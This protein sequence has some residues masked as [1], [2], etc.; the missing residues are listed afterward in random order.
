M[1]FGVLVAPISRLNIGVHPRTQSGKG[2]SEN[3]NKWYSGAAPS[4]LR[5]DIVVA[6]RFLTR[7]PIGRSGET[8]TN[9]ASAARAFSLVGAAVGL[10]GSVAFGLAILVGLPPFLAALIA[11]GALILVTGALHEDGLADAADGMGGSTPRV[12]LAI[13]RD[14]RIGVFGALALILSVLARAGALTALAAPWPAAMAL[15]AAGSLSRG[16][17][18]GIMSR[19]GLASKISVAAAAGT[20]ST[21]TAA[22]AAI[23][24]GVLSII[25]LGPTAGFVVIALAGLI[26][27][28]GGRLARWF[29]GGYNGDLLGAI[30]QAVE[31]VVLLG[32]VAMM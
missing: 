14:S 2:M 3:S 18:P 15:I 21:A 24:G 6:T 9:L 13:M 27:C 30:Q 16:I 26:A 29:L 1:N 17:L 5:R 22:T 25:C 4:I 32:V 19:V 23:V 28:I 11:L 8:H 7:I 20:P 31:T 10:I 12:R